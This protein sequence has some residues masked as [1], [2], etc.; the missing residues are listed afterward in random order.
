MTQ[1]NSS[2]PISPPLIDE[3]YIPE[4]VLAHTDDEDR[5]QRVQRI[6]E[7]VVFEL[8]WQ[9]RL[10]RL[11]EA[12]VQEVTNQL[13]QLVE[14]LEE[15]EAKMDRLDDAAEALHSFLGQPPIS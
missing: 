6:L 7:A 5:H 15:E 1:P 3:P 13:Q 2:Q 8:G 9:T 4:D 12:H 10:F 11:K 14:D